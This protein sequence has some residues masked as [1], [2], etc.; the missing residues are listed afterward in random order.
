MGLCYS[1]MWRRPAIG[2]WVASCYCTHL[3]CCLQDVSS[4]DMH[5][6]QAVERSLIPWDALRSSWAF[7]A[8]LS[9]TNFEI[10]PV[11]DDNSERTL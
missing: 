9:L 4:D 3:I 7:S 2:H 10:V 1:Q 6:T 11:S 5:D 8:Q